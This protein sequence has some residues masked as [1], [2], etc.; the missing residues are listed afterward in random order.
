MEHRYLFLDLQHVTRIERLYRRIHQP[1]RHPNNPILRGEN[2]WESVA[3]LYGTVLYDPQD[4]RFKMWYL[5]GPYVDGMVKIRQRNALGNV[6]LLAYATSTDG[7][8]WE[9]PILNQVDFEGST[10]NNLVDIGRTNCEGA[11]IIYDTHETDPDRRYKG[12][13]WEHGG[14]DTFTSA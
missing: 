10:E 14:I 2:P 9:K 11:A 7:V 5:T 4:S 13:Y 3:S 1:Q 6:T 12:F 8:Q